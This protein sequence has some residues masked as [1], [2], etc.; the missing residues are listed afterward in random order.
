MDRTVATGTGFIGQYP[1]AVAKMYES[2]A[3]CPD[4]LLLFMHHVPYTHVAAFGQ[5]RHPVHLRLALRGR[6]RGGE[7]GTTRGGRCAGRIDDQRYQAVLTQL[8]YQAG[9]A[10]VWRD[11]VTRWFHRTS[12][13]SDETGRASARYPGRI[14]AESAQLQATS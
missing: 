7:V 13:I 10:I 9:Q 6:R 5:D 1:P 3:T 12:G 11:A 14:E 2:L 4:D 8:D